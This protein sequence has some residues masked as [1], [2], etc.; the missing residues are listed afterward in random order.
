MTEH[1]GRQPAPLTRDELD[2][3]L[4]PSRIA[5]DAAGLLKRHAAATAALDHTAGLRVTRDV[6]YGS[7]PRQKMDICLPN[8][9]KAAP[10]LVF[11]HG[12]FWQE[13]SKAWSGFA[14]PALAAEGWAHVGIGYTLA[15]E[16][17]LADIL[18]EIAAA[19]LALHHIA[20]GHGIDPDRII[21]AG[22]SAGA[23]L[24]AALM[25]GIG[26]ADVLKTIAGAVLISGVYE[27]SPVAASYV[28]DAMHL[29]PNDVASLSPMRQR[30][31]INPPCLILIGADESPSFQWQSD[32][33]FDL[34]RPHLAQISFI[35]VEGRDHFD[36]L[37]EMATS[38][39][40]TFQT[41]MAMANLPQTGKMTP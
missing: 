38:N 17:G 37:D 40:S 24:V 25:S 2:A 20:P 10:C 23:H 39:S 15:P 35:R 3:Q 22:H 11:V 30:P 7:G 32:T 16:A 9:A 41:V 8:G 31:R 21:V 29:S 5:K 26:G 36:I 27:L 34:W 19:L 28:N 4:S 14:A 33:L 12:G 6:A 13:G 18:A 1:S